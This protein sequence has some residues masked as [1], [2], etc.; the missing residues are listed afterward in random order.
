MINKL[1]K[2]LT[3]TTKQL[4]TWR[5]ENKYTLEDVAESV[6]LAVCTICKLE[7]NNV[8][9]SAYVRTLFLGKLNINLLNNE[10]VTAQENKISHLQANVSTLENENEALRTKLNDLHTLLQRTKHSLI[11]SCNSGRNVKNTYYTVRATIEDCLNIIEQEIGID[12]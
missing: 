11:I 12:S 3:L 5:K 10:T 2:E 9:I 8:P 6:G 7:R 1:E 4:R